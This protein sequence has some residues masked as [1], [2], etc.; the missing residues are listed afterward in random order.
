MKQL[1]NAYLLIYNLSQALGWFYLNYIALPYYKTILVSGTSSGEM[2]E[3][4]KYT[5][6][7][8]L[9]IPYLEVIHAV[10]G[11]VKSSPMPTFF[12][13]TMRAFV[14][15]AVCDHYKP[16]QTSI[17]F[18]TM[19]LVWNMSEVIRYSYYATN[20]MGIP[21]RGSTWLRYTLFIV[22]YPIGACSEVLCMFAALPDIKNDHDRNITMPNK[23]NAT[24]NFYYFI[25]ILMLLY[26]PYLIT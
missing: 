4:V 18:P 5:L 2:Y 10:L 3:E 8:L 23:W 21:F 9:L 25:I 26:I 12:Q 20:L 11:F 1:I 17:Q 13:V 19:V 6:K 14:F 15:I 16:V 24:F 22:L 7:L